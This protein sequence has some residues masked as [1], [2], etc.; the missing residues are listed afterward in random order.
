M[1]GIQDPSSD[2]RVYLEIIPEGGSLH[3][4]ELGRNGGGGVERCKQL[5]LVLG[6]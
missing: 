4:L 1:N 6:Q 3:R 2:L 5:D